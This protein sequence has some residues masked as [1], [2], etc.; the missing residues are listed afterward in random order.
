MERKKWKEN[1]FSR[2]HIG[3]LIKL[4]LITGGLM[5]CLNGF[6]QSTKLSLNL[7]NVS[8]EQ[9]FNEIKTQSGYTMAYKNKDIDLKKQVSIKVENKTI[10]E[11]LKQILE[12]QGVDFRITNKHIVLA[13][14]GLP[15]TEKAS[16][17]MKITGTIK[18]KTG[19]ELIGAT[20]VE[21]GTNNG[22]ATDADG[23]FTLST[24]PNAILLVSYIGFN[25]KEISVDGNNKLSL[26][27]EDD[28]RILDEVVVTALGI[29]REK[30]ALGYSMQELTGDGMTETRDPNVANALSGKVAGLQ[31][32]QSG[33]GPAGS[34]RIILR[35][36]NSL[37]GNNQ[38]LIIVD[39]VPID[40]T[41]GGSDDFWG[42]KSVDR[43]SGLADVSPDDIETVSVLKGPAAAAL[44]G[45]RAGNGVILITTK[46]GV[47]KGMGISLNSNI[48]FENPMETPNMQNTY[49][50]GIDGKFDNNASTSWGEV[51]SGQAVKDYTTNSVNP[52]STRETNAYAANGNN[53]YDNFL[54]TGTTWTNSIDLSAAG[55]NS[56]FRAALVNMDNKGVIPN[57]GM[58][59]TSF[60]LRSTGKWDKLSSDAKITFVTQKTNNR[61]K[62]AADP[63]NIFHNYLMTPRSVNFSD[64]GNQDIFPNYGFP[65]GSNLGGIDVGGKP[66][67]WTSNYNGN[68][69]NPNW[70]AYNNTNND[71]KNRYY[72]FF[73]LKYDF[74]EYLNLQIRSGLDMFNSKYTMIQATGT[75]YWETG[76]DYSVTQ[77]TF[78]ESNSDF[79]LNFNKTFNEKIGLVASFGGNTMRYRSDYMQG[80]AGGVVIP[81]FYKLINGKD[82]T[83][84]DDIVSAQTNS[85][86]GLMSL[87]YD[88]FIYLDITGRNDWVS[89]LNP[90]NRSFF[91]PSV[92]LSLLWT[93]MLS[94]KNISTGPISFGKLRASW[95]EVGNAVNPYQ[96]RN[97]VDMSIKK[98][99]NPVTET[100]ENVVL[101]QKSPIMPL[102]DLK[103]EKIQ[104]WEIGVE[105]KAFNNRVGLDFTYYNK[106][107]KNQIL[108]VQAPPASG[109]QLKYA[110]AGNVNN[111]GLEIVFLGTPIATRAINWDIALNFAKNTSKIVELT[112]DT[113]EQIL[114]SSNASF[115][116]VVAREGGAYGDL[117]GTTFVRDDKGSIVVD[118]K[119]LPL[120]NSEFSR[121]GNFNP[122]WMAGISNTVTF[123]NLSLN[124]LIDMRYGG[125][126]YM[127]SIMRGM[128]AGTLKESLSGRTGMLVNGVTTDGAINTVETKSQNYNSRLAD[129]TEPWIYD[130]TNIRLREMSLGFNFPK[131]IIK[132]TPL[133]SVKMSLVARNILMLY[134]K[135]NGFDPEAGY[136]TSNAQGIEFGS[137]PTMRSLG[138]NLNVVF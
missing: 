96:L 22:T 126:V 19:L 133:N 85:L 42:N 62:L 69:R 33:T 137:M 11:V 16:E 124:F 123:K 21:K 36:N 82:Q 90:Q 57:S 119:G 14:K 102:D 52:K 135:T 24:A 38:P 101:G 109:Y 31:I 37:M 128:S 129:I 59:K 48:T 111:K 49:G 132:K 60:T 28:T 63:D 98:V 9:A 3:H 79:L 5:M 116:R 67:S 45:S 25:A 112:D 115:I 64:L 55:D 99:Y 121:L 77:E 108:K 118:D 51:M 12:G 29:K 131:S 122:D 72:G 95:A 125:D 27:L 2:L 136:T 114:G 78:Y 23:N 13:K 30:K 43:G 61:I 35:G 92:G 6:S 18:D 26:T 76:G 8:L 83:V 97:Y 117:Y 127:G 15:G 65:L 10:E 106:D 44:Y 53:L 40:N 47:K 20:V 56:T 86:Y 46:K 75:P 1:A 107:A 17:K 50:Q 32:K 134:S 74:T 70:A 34:S 110:N 113:K 73:S 58:D 87:S 54:R 130:A 104:S 94:R 88:N 41:T 4:T 66:A 103:S 84:V 7:E 68:V 39:G 120:K 93:E 100:I 81:N 138:F 89:T 105:L 80:N 71:R 91:Y